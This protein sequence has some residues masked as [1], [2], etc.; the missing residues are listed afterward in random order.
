M[1]KTLFATA[2]FTLITSTVAASTDYDDSLCDNVVVHGLSYHTDRNLIKDVREINFGLGC[3]VEK[4]PLGFMEYGFFLNSFDDLTVYAVATYNG[5]DGLGW[6]FYGG[7]GTG[8]YEFAP[9]PF[10]DIGL[11]GLFGVAYVDED[12]TVRITPSYDW[13]DDEIGLVFG[14]SYSVE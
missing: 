8:Y 12:F 5:H 3:R 9:G 1:L 6:G 10:Q 7:L 13:K 2:T 11:V 14:L 4:Y